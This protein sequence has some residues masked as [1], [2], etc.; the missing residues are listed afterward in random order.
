MQSFVAGLYPS[1]SCVQSLRTHS[2]HHCRRGCLANQTRP[3]TSGTIDVV[4]FF[5]GQQGNTGHGMA[6]RFH[7]LAVP[8]AIS[9]PD[10]SS[11]AFTQ[12]VI[13]LC[14][15]LKSR[16]H[17][18]IFYGHEPSVVDCTDLVGVTT[19]DDLQRSYGDHD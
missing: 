11:C 3:C 13:K 10:Y 2:R 18:V 4:D 12:K 19:N 14:R 15:M 16:G 5:H 8:H 6:H 9:T 17:A 1:T 7:I